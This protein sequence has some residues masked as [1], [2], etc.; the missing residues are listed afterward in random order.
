MNCFGEKE[1]KP[2]DPN[3]FVRNEAELVSDEI[4]WVL[5]WYFLVTQQF[6]MMDTFSCPLWDYF[7]VLYVLCRFRIKLDFLLLFQSLN[8]FTNNFSDARMGVNIVWHKK[9][10]AK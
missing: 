8:K 9:T 4:I 6:I 2:S 3:N 5:G 1:F 10:E 7:K